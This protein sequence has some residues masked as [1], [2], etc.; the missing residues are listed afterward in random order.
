[1]LTAVGMLVLFVV[2]FGSVS[3]HVYLLQSQQKIDRLTTQSQ[4]S[5][6]RYDHLRVT[7]DQLQS[8]A[9]IVAAA[10]RLGMVEA[11]DSTWLAPK[12]STDPSLKST[13]ATQS[14]LDDSHD[15]SEVKPYLEA[16]P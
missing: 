8:P 4:V 3:F 7:V 9:R 13:P 5:Q 11:A 15:Y 10:R 2:L 16:T 1:M 6:A 12:G 14:G